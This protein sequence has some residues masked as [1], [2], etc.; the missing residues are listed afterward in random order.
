MIR[1]VSRDQMVEVFP[2]QNALAASLSNEPLSAGLL[3]IA[4]QQQAEDVLDASHCLVPCHVPEPADDDVYVRRI[5][6][7][8]VAAP[9]AHMA[10]ID[11]TQHEHLLHLRSERN[12]RKLCLVV[13]LVREFG[14]RRLVTV[15]LHG[16]PARVVRSPGAVCVEGEVIDPHTTSKD[17]EQIPVAQEKD[18][19]SARSYEMQSNSI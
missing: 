1:K 9:A 5:G 11:A 3:R 10:E 17:I 4:T 15:P 2:A 12:G 13:V 16:E 8:R 18:R 19:A 14:I 7:N 6:A